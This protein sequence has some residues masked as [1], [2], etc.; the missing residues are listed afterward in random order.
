[1][2][3]ICLKFSYV[4]QDIGKTAFCRT[5]KSARAIPSCGFFIA[6]GVPLRQMPSGG[7][8]R[9]ARLRCWRATRWGGH[10]EKSWRNAWL[11]VVSERRQLPPGRPSRQGARATTRY[12]SDDRWGQPTKTSSIAQPWR[13]MHTHAPRTHRQH[14]A[15][16]PTDRGLRICRLAPVDFTKAVWMPRQIRVGV[17]TEPTWGQ[18]VARSGH[19]LLRHEILFPQ[20]SLE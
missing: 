16:C 11:L 17:P 18:S 5:S 14:A 7:A 4:I 2:P 6:D 19:A 12:D 3:T 13:S 10:F 8:P 15:V 1:M 20:S 9:W